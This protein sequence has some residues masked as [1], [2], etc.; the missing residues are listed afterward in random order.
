VVF[1][2]E[3]GTPEFPRGCLPPLTGD[4]RGRVGPPQRVGY[5]GAPKR[6]RFGGA[7][8]IPG[9][10]DGEQ[11][12]EVPLREDADA[13]ELPEL[14][15]LY[16]PAVLAAPQ[17]ERHDAHGRVLGVD[18]DDVGTVLV[19]VVAEPLCSLDQVPGAH[20]GGEPEAPRVPDTA[21]DGYSLMAH[22]IVSSKG[23]PGNR[24]RISAGR[25]GGCGE[26]RCPSRLATA[27]PPAP[28]P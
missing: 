11:G 26:A 3:A 21:V 15:V 16:R 23:W 25:C 1:D 24:G 8:D 20:A 14:R 2:G 10:C 5:R 6:V 9:N 19:G 22:T 27:E 4:V 18:P 28:E 7:T 13:V 12:G 17:G